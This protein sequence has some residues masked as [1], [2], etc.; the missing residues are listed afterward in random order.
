[1]LQQLLK[2]NEERKPEPT[3]QDDSL[4]R[5]LGFTNSPSP[6][7]E[8]G[9]ARK[10]P[11]DDRDENPSKRP[12]EAVSS[13][14]VSSGGS[15]LCE[16]NKMLAS[17]LAKQPANNHLPIPP[18][19]ASVIS[20]TPQEILPKVVDLNKNPT[21][22][23]RI[24]S[25]L[26]QAMLA[27]PRAVPRM[28]G[29]GRPPNTNYLNQMLTPG[30]N[31]QRS[32]NRQFNQIDSGSYVPATSNVDIW[33][34]QSSSDPLLSD[35][36]DQVIDIVPDA[37]MT[38]STDL[39]NLLE[40]IDATQNNNNFQQREPISEKMAINIIQKSLMQC[41]SAVNKSPSSPTISLSGTPP[42]YSSTTVSYLKKK[43]KNNSLILD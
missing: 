2:E 7:S 8:P 22:S 24:P 12:T 17:L 21:S 34:I 30:D 6:P 14:G 11:S 43:G 39:L 5:S 23:A 4:L 28:P 20:A 15:K 37:V 26:Q 38:N 33:D 3:S 32:Q 29:P 16:R 19:P 35:I 13:T 27:N 18:V 9:R 25:N 41:E 36:L 40:T 42:A 31:M 1:M 10:R